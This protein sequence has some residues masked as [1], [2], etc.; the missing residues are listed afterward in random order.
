MII[1]FSL[2]A[3]AVNTTLLFYGLLM[4]FKLIHDE[5]LRI[6]LPLSIQRLN[7]KFIA[8]LL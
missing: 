3:K 6:A 7:R 8:D 4:P 1:N 2:G 5:A